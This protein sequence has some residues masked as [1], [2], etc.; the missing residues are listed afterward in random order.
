MRSRGNEP[1]TKRQGGQEILEF[2]LVALLL[3]VPM[4][5]GSFV[6]GMNLIKT[7]Q[8][9]NTI[10]DIANMFIHG[11]DLSDGAYQTLVQGSSTTPG[12]ATGLNLIA[13]VNA[14]GTQTRDDTGTTGDGVIW[15]SKVMYVG[16]GGGSNA[17]NFVFLQRIRIGN[18]NLDAS[19]H[20]SFLG[21]PSVTAANFLADGEVNTVNCDPR[22]C[23][24]AKLAA[25]PEAAMAALW[26]TTS[27]VLTSLVDGQIVYVS[28]GY[29]QTPQFGMGSNYTS[30]G[31]YA[32]Y[33]F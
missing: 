6:V 19:P 8:A 15:I 1:T 18:R 29:F 30:G 5:L 26:L 16:T 24:T 20:V 25:G 23:A 7:I 4:L 10:R 2:G 17:G 33:F 9:K 32:R 3:Y 14:A 28:E 12:I 22:N 11:A 27:G 31:V 21:T 13:P